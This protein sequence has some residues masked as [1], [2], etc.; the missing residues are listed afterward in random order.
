MT[1]SLK[2]DAPPSL[3]ARFT[4]FVDLRRLHGHVARLE[5]CNGG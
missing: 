5:E 2:A 4:V 1:F 3:R